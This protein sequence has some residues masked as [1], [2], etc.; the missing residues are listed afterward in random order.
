MFMDFLLQ[1]WGGRARRESANLSCPE[2]CGPSVC[3][4]PHPVGVVTLYPKETGII[5][6]KASCRTPSPTTEESTKSSRRG[7]L[8]VSDVPLGPTAVSVDLTFSL[9]TVLFHN[10][11]KFV[12]VFKACGFFS[13]WSMKGFLQGSLYT[14]IYVYTCMVTERKS[15]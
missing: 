7:E 2:D 1:E 15:A 8:C 12:C 5:P 4:L 9:A 14:A 10:L 11:K 13:E 3:L 6:L